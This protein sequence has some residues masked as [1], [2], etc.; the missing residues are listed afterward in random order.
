MRPAESLRETYGKKLVEIGHRKKDVV[1]L[2]A[3]L[4]SSTTTSEFGEIF[5]D[6]FS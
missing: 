3:D 2:D 1:V 6:R 5:P 4:S